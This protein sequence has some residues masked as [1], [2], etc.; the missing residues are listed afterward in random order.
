MGK[1]KR[2]REERAERERHAE[3][4]RARQDRIASA[5][6][7]RKLDWAKSKIDAL[8]DSIQ[9]WLQGDAYTLV[10][11]TEAVTGDQV[12]EAKITEPPPEEW[13][14]MVGDAV[15]N[16]RSALDH[17]A[18]Q[19][20]LDGYQADRPGEAI[21]AGHQRRIMFPIVAVSNDPRLSVEEFY[22]QVV[23]AQLRYV[24]DSA[25]AAIQTLQPYERTPAA[26]LTDPLWAV[27]EIDVIDKHRKLHTTAVAF[28]IKEFSIGG[29][30]VHIKNLKIGG[31]SVED[32]SEVMRWNVES[33]GVTPVKMEG[34]F[35]RHIGLT[36]IPAGD[37][38]SV[39]V[40]Q[41][42]RVCHHYIAHTVIGALKAF[43]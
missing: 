13:P 28:P 17:V 36:D 23:K 1:A 8:E 5:S 14:L 26:P 4:Q 25:A 2:L 21:P 9:G 16:L 19:L 7:S 31:G 32:N 42:L 3:E 43:L 18:Y 12:L 22:A 11:Y 24:P 33:I 41:V 34:R 30:D 29:G 20:A 38:G 40:V 10:E 27:N 15:H 35:S 6:Y 39:D 37:Y